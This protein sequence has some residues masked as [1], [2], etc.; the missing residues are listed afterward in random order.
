MARR[1][2]RPVVV[3]DESAEDLRCGIDESGRR[4]HEAFDER[5]HLSLKLLQRTRVQVLEPSDS[6]ANT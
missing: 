5:V 2:N 3:R 4:V 6:T 1:K